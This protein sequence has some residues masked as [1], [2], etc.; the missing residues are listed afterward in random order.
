MH[1]RQ[2]GHHTKEAGHGGHVDGRGRLLADVHFLVG[3]VVHYGKGL[4]GDIS[5]GDICCGEGEGEG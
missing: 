4:Q 1:V 2:Q 5:R 3:D